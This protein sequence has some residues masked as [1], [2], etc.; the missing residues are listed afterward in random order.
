MHALLSYL[1]A[2]YMGT[3]PAGLLPAVYFQTSSSVLFSFPLCDMSRQELDPYGNH[4]PQTLTC[5]NGCLIEKQGYINVHLPNSIWMPLFPD[6]AQ[7]NLL[8]AAPPLGNHCRSSPIELKNLTLTEIIALKHR[9]AHSALPR[10]TLVANRRG[11]HR[12][13]A[14]D[15][16]RSDHGTAARKSAPPSSV[17]P[18]SSSDAILHQRARL[19]GRRGGA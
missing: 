2:V 19:C 12:T 3:R 4:C 5:Q 13:A 8:Y 7:K 1:K 10:V 9:R 14:S 15:V 11:G 17:P 6:R 16:A 18:S